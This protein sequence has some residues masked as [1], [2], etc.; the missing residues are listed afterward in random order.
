MLPVK[1]PA[2]ALA[3]CRSGFEIIGRPT[4]EE[5]KKGAASSEINQA[6]GF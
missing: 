5:R 3:G 2:A 1:T 4:S 6:P